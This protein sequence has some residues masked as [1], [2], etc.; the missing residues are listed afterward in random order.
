[1][2]TLNVGAGVILENTANNTSF[3]N[4]N[5]C[6]IIGLAA[7]LLI[8]SACLGNAAM[9]TVDDGI[10]SADYSS[11][12]DAI[13]DSRPGD[14]ILVSPGIY[15]E[16]VNVDRQLNISS[17]DGAVVTKVI[18]ASVYDHVFEVTADRV[19]ISG[20]TVS[21]DTIGNYENEIAGIYLRSNDNKLT[22]NILYENYCGIALNDSNNN[23]LTG[24]TAL[25]DGGEYGIHV[26]SSSNNTVSNNVVYFTGTYITYGISQEDSNN[27]RLFNNS[28]CG[29]RYSGI[30]LRNS[31]YN[32]LT[33]NS[34][35]NTDEGPGIHISSSNYN[36][37]TNNVANGY[38]GILV[39]GSNNLLDSNSIR[40]CVDYIISVDGSNNTLTN[41]TATDNTTYSNYDDFN[42]DQSSSDNT[43]M[44]AIL[45]LPFT[46]ST[47]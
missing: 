10:S 46:V 47:W 4:I 34:V 31:N 8:A 1:M 27:N 5:Y 22:N 24:N 25:S 13:N 44:E 36:L 35:T 21:S 42:I 28:V 33:G 17:T 14:T 38:S 39:S 37:L 6:R 2:K 7:I 26:Y 19:T 43:I 12:Q 29:S 23:E 41:N 16:N 30:E 11:I 3:C 9:I 20:F 18:S 45:Q 32:I 40:Y 15:N